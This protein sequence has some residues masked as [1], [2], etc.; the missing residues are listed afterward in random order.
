MRG[1]L[2]NGAEIIAA[3]NARGWTQKQLAAVTELDVKTI[4]K[5]EQGQRIDLRTLNRFAETLQLHISRLIVDEESA[6][7]SVLRRALVVQ[8]HE[9]W[10]ARDNDSVLAVYTEDAV[11]TLPGDP[12]V[13]YGGAHRGKEAIGRA[14]A[15]AWNGMNLLPL[16]IEDCL[17]LVSEHAVTLSG[18]KGIVQP[19]G[20][21]VWFPTIH[22]FQ[23]RDRLIVKHDVQF[24]TL[25]LVRETQLPT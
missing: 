3:R 2:S 11:L 14:N 7:E 21:V 13:P 6:D 4:R 18:S 24:D 20:D 17:I 19:S 1:V 9:A 22:I 8:W 10:E 5:A 15:I 16:P 23:F 12:T 25:K